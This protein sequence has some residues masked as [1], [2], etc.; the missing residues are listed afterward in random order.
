MIA[1]GEYRDRV[2]PP[3]PSNPLGLAAIRLQEGL[4]VYL[5]DTNHRELFERDYRALSHGCIR[6]EHW[7]ELIAWLL[8]L[9]LDTVHRFA[10]GR[11][12]FDLPTP[13]VPVILGYFTVFP[14]DAGS[15]VR[16]ED[17]YRLGNEVPVPALL[18]QL[19]AGLPPVPAR[20]R[21]ARVTRRARARRLPAPPRRAARRR[22]SASRQ[23]APRARPGV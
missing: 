15:P 7:D 22:R 17:V 3:G 1:S 12:T 5:H 23:V 16:F 11:G 18:E 13:P 9:D 2:W 10:N 20:S 19:P 6:V 14:D 8:D 21:P 4:L